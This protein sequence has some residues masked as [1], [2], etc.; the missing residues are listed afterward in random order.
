MDNRISEIRRSIRALRVS[1]REAEAV[2]H[3]Q[4][5]RDDD[6]TFVAQ[7]IIRMRTVMSELVQERTKLGDTT[8]IV[9]ASIFIPRRLPA[10][11][12]GRIP[13]RRL[14]PGAARVNG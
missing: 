13:K 1:V 2:M 8:P 4:I 10:P 6:C 3:E 11:P 9:V 14:V 7:E 5:N 12:R